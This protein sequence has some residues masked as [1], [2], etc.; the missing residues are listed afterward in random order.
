MPFALARSADLLAAGADGFAHAYSPLGAVKYPPG[1]T[2]YDYV[3][4][5]APKGGAMRFARMGAFDTANTLTYPG[6]PPSDIRLIYDRLIVASNDERATYYGLLAE[7]LRV[8]EDFARIEFRLHPDARWHD[9]QPVVAEDVVFTF[10]TL[11]EKGAPFYRQAFGPLSVFADT[12]ET[13]VFENERLGDRD[14]VRRISTIPIHPAHVWK[15]DPPLN[16]PAA[17]IGSGPYKVVDIDPPR[18]LALKRV[19]DYWARELPVNR[20]RWN[21]DSLIFFYFR[22]AGVALEAFRAD[23][24]DIR[25]E[26]SPTRWRS[27][28]DGAAL[29][30]GAIRRSLGRGRGAG[31][32]HGL[33]FNL[34]RP[35]LADRRV[36]LAMALAYDF[37][38]INRTLFGGVQR[39]LES[40]FG[41]T[42][43][44]AAGPA[45][46]AERAI[47]AAKAADLPDAVFATPDPLEGLPQPGSRDAFLAA[48][49]LLAEA[50]LSFDG[51]RLIDPATDRPVSLKVVS[52]NPLYERPLGLIEEAWG[53]LGIA[54]ERVHAD[55]ATASRQ[56]LDRDFDLA[57]V[58]WS[59][60]LLP[61]T[62]ERLLWHSDLA[63]QEGSYALSGLRDAALDAAIEALERARTERDLTSAAR[64][65]DR[66]FRQ[67]MPML[68]LWS[69]NDIR[70]AWWDRF[71]RPDSETSGFPPSPMDRW[72]VR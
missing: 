41:E 57:T 35:L 34:R 50:G 4:P 21:A 51:G 33:V 28:Y 17:L 15:D 13:V 63:S 9:G 18:R 55:R 36:R 46:E 49:G 2:A 60:A 69:S 43:L 53:R 24:Y 66:V 25:F 26:D 52:P 37:D 59:P 68:P 7:S 30:S 58:S 42:E 5:D 31:E 38:A 45:D 1:F 22:D 39:P 20:G 70:L 32:V 12:P 40:V 27:G 3:N 64:A 48:N 16:D 29:T 19:P 44:A 10:E 62:A 11:K 8:A 71:G 23:D 67:T 65:F 47:L 61:G 72:W 6:R 56:M 14:V 54:L